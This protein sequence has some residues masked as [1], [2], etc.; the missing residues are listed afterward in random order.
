MLEQYVCWQIWMSAMEITG[1]SMAVRT[2]WVDT[3]AA[4]LKVICSITSGTSVWV[5]SAQKLS[6]LLCLSVCVCDTRTHT[7]TCTRTHTH[8]HTHHT[9]HTHIQSF[10][11]TIASLLWALWVQDFPFLEAQ[12]FPSRLCR[13]KRMSNLFRALTSQS[14]LPRFPSN[15]KTHC[16]SSQ[17]ENKY[18]C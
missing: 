2:W 7:H 6:G 11:V 13:V 10:L 9:H 8:T 15:T 3:A 14:N 5:S 4:V 17:L 18:L 16:L 12:P 1:A